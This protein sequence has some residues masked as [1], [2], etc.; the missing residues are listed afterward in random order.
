MEIQPQGAIIEV[1]IIVPCYNEENTIRLLLQ[2]I[3]EQDYSKE[4]LEVIIADA[5]SEDHTLEQI[6]NFADKN[7]SLRINVVENYKRTIPAA[8]NLAA[9]KSCGKYLIRLDAHS[10]PDKEYISTSVD[11]LEKEIAQN[12]GGIWDIRP[13]DNSCVAKAIA[14]AAS[15]P[16]GAGDASYRLSG[17]ASFVD[18]VPFGAFS[19]N[20]FEKVGGFNEKLLS[21]EDYEFNVRIRKNGGKIWLDPRIRSQYFARKNFRELAHQYG[22]YGFWKY[23]M[24][25]AYPDTIRWRQAVPPLFCLAIYFFGIISFFLP[26]A[27]IIVA[28]ILTSYLLLLTI[29]AIIEALKKRD[30]CYI[31]LIVAF[32]VMHLCWGNSF[33]F[34]MISRKKGN[35]K[36]IT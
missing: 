24:I 32:A 20:T 29:V 22:R 36:K 18:T 1:S 25:R 35:L 3:L 27:R 34:S 21:N 23:Q 33:I 2:A 15:H 7:P 14:R 10:I 30:F 31:F 13:G 4:K 12:V 8:I 26:F 5:L 17:K 11:L 9:E 16:I 6:K 28:S 19:K